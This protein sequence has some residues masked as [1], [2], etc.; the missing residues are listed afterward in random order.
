MLIIFKLA[1]DG[2]SGTFNQKL[3]EEYPSALDN[4]ELEVEAASLFTQKNLRKPQ[5]SVKVKWRNWPD[6]TIEP[7]KNLKKTLKT[8]N[9][10][11]DKYDIC[12]LFV[13]YICL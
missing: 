9:D 3:S 2:R 13:R 4:G 1:N 7:L 10:A 6:K 12:K 5:G 11:I 8:V